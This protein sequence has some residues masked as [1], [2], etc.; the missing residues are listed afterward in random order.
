MHSSSNSS[1]PILRCRDI[2]KR[3]RN[4]PWLSWNGYD[5]SRMKQISSSFEFSLVPV[6]GFVVPKIF[7]RKTRML[8]GAS[9]TLQYTSGLQFAAPV[10]ISTHIAH[11]LPQPIPLHI[12]P[13]METHAHMT[14]FPYHPAWPFIVVL[15]AYYTNKTDMT[16]S[17]DKPQTR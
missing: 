16:W 4:S 1:H 10:P 15:T 3:C 13:H 12:R 11:L 9:E 14:L 2:K 7:I 8:Y 17:P 6:A 5:M